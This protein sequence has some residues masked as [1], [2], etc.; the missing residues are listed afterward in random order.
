MSRQINKEAEDTKSVVEVGSLVDEVKENK[1]TVKS[2]VTI[3]V[4]Y[5]AIS[6][7]Q[8]IGVVRYLQIKPQNSG[9]AAILK[10]KYAMKMY[11]IAQWDAIVDELLNRKIS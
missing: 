4:G 8:K 3:S 5:A 9:V 6:P 1:V 7:T 11:T 10:K 2:P